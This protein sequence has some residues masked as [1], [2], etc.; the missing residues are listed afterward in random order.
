LALL[1]GSIVPGEISAEPAGLRTLGVVVVLKPR[2]CWMAQQHDGATGFLLAKGV[3]SQTPG[4]IGKVLPGAAFN[5]PAAVALSGFCEIGGTL[6]F[7]GPPLAN[8]SPC[9][10]LLLLLPQS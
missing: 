7:C 4:A 9:V 5:G 6:R 3:H 1:R 10:L 2:V 8:E